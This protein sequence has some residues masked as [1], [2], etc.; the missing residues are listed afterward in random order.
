MGSPA[1]WSQE[2]TD[3]ATISEVVVTGTRVADRSRL[4]T[5]SAVDVLPETKLTS[6]GTTEL[7]QALSN[8]APSLNFPRPAVTD[9]TDSIRPA[10]LRGLSPDQTLVL[11][12]SKRRHASALV[13]LN[14][15]V[16]RGSAAVDLNAIPLVAI[17]R[18]EVLRDGASA[19]YGSD[20]IAGVLNLHLREAREGGEASL[21]YGAND[22][23]V[24][25][26]LGSRHASDGQSF[27]ASAW[28]G[29]SLGS[30][31]F[32]TLSAEYRNDDPTSRGDYDVRPPLTSPTITSRYGDPDSRNVSF[33]ANAGLPLA[34]GWDIYGWAGYQDRDSESATLPRLA[35]N[36]NNVA[37]L[38]PN[39]FLPLIT[40]SVKD[41]TAAIGTRGS[42][43][44]WDTDISLVYGRNN[45]D[46][47]AIHTL[48][49][50]YGAASPTRFDAGSLTYD[51]FVF[52]LGLVRGF[53]WGLAQPV[54]VAWGAEARRE[55]YQIGAGEPSSYDR[56]TVAPTL[57][58]GAQ[59]FP[60][61]QPSNEVD[62]DR[63][64][65]GVYVDIESQITEK[66][67]AS[68]AGR[69]EHYSDFGSEATGK[70]SARYDFTRS[71][72]LRGTVSTGFRAPSLQQ[73]FFTSTAT[74][75]TDGV[76]FDTGTFPATS[77]V[78]RTLGAKDLNPEKSKN[79]SLGAVF[80]FDKFDATVDA[81]RI[82][83]RDRIVLSENLSGGDVTTL[84]APF[85]VTAARFFINGVQT[86]TDGVDA[87]L[88]YPLTTERAGRFD[89]TLAGNYN[90]TDVT[91]V[92]T[93]TSALPGVVLFARQ[94]QLRFE[95]GTPRTKVSLDTDWSYR[96]AFGTVGTTLRATR[97][98]KVLAAGTQ[99]DGSADVPIDSAWVVD[100]ELTA[101]LNDHVGVG[102]GADNLFDEYPTEVPLALNTTA[103]AAFSPFS[104]FGFNGRFIHARASYKW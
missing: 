46:Y 93:G 24:D 35:N 96:T 90:E 39:G 36:A 2:Q 17:D 69:G 22:T 98:G 28:N 99:A 14:G 85:S 48:N 59:G 61:L 1:A 101:D 91:E 9:G 81:Y 87:V 64:A 13:N 58:P 23:T 52:N 47:G 45:I 65:Y 63:T 82:D 80:R 32:L 20:A 50:T 100:L 26:P 84:L 73:E 4:D 15:S 38:F 51:E 31:G 102:V 83:I 77:A 76:P 86:R 10:T 95:D 70:F 5:L 67:L 12:D 40:T 19:Q 37:T 21:T 62:E 94:N 33:Y 103:A 66:F 27:T 97:Y 78:A 30:D 54:N 92:Q 25:T 6:Q 53:D 16:G 74:V 71:F 75:F 56:G 57:T 89:F 8:V 11:V 60:G 49:A 29:F 7:A 3:T 44:D 88:H 104:P 34:S 18:I 68:I 55:S 41:A 42:L 72:A 79:Y 43:A